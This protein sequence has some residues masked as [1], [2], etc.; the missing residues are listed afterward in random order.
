MTNETQTQE[1][2]QEAAPPQ[3]GKKA[4]QAG[5]QGRRSYFMFDP[6]E[7]I[8]VGL[9]TNDGPE[10]PLWDERIKL[11]LDE[12]L[13]RNIQTYGVI[14]PILFVRDGDKTYVVDGRRRVLHAR[15]AAKRQA[16][17]GEELVKVPG[18]PKRG[19]DTYL[20][21]ISRSANACRV[22]DGPLTNARN[23]QRMLD[24]GSSEKEIAVAFGVKEQTV[25]DWLSLLG[26]A[27]KV[28]TAVAKG[29]LS[30][31]AAATLAKLSKEE[32]EGHL[33]ELLA[34]GAKPTVDNVINKV[35]TSKGKA[36]TNT[37]KVRIEKAEAL[38]AKAAADW[39]SY[40]KDELIDLVDKLSKALLSKGIAKLQAELEKEAA[41]EDE[42]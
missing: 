8:V 7:L 4:K 21:G 24:M 5:D 1:Q 23:A 42:E 38:L 2:E 27:P 39:G 15:E 14:E 29:V 26:L 6:D 17:A 22:N 11:P 37:P 12:G 33:E 41:A 35:R 16:Q 36:P 40:T 28:K 34:T 18:I 25:K 19:E 32:Q 10:H 13:V 31:S 30:P 9:D 3:N 20:F